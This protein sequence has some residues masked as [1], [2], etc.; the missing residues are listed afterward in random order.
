MQ[1]KTQLRLETVKIT[2]ITQICLT[3]DLS[4]NCN[5]AYLVSDKMLIGL[6]INFSS[7]CQAAST[8]C[9]IRVHSC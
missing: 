2:I 8:R 9:F 7:R 5:R 3:F 4:T 1:E 6:N